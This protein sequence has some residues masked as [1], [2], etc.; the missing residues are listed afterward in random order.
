MSAVHRLP[1]L[2]A[3]PGEKRPCLYWSGCI[4]RFLNL[5][6]RERQPGRRSGTG[7]A[8]TNKE[9]HCPP[10]CRDFAPDAPS[11]EEATRWRTNWRDEA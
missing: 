4:T 11:V 8:P 2:I 5:Q 10:Q 9:A 1:M 3:G 6:G 7:R